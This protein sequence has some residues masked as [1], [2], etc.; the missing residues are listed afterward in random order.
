MIV[1]TVNKK[2]KYCGFTAHWRECL[3]KM[4]AR[5]RADIG[6][7]CVDYLNSLNYLCM[8]FCPLYLFFE[9]DLFE[10]IFQDYT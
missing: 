2:I 9:S 6:N 10:K 7:T 3:Q 4:K 5:A 1:Q 8:P